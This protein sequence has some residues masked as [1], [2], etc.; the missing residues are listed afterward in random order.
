MVIPQILCPPPPPAST[1]QLNLRPL[2]TFRQ[3]KRCLV[4]VLGALKQ[5]PILQCIP[6]GGGGEF[7]VPAYIFFSGG[8]PGGGGGGGTKKN[9]LRGKIFLNHKA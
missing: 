1:L 9:N 4:G 6:G 2:L 5:A 3:V 8:T 7:L